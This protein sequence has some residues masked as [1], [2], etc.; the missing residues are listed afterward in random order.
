MIILLSLVY[1]TRDRFPQPVRGRVQAPLQ[2]SKTPGHFFKNSIQ[3]VVAL[4]HS[5]QIRMDNKYQQSGKHRR[6]VSEHGGPRP[7][8]NSFAPRLPNTH[9]W[10]A[11]PVYG[12]WDSLVNTV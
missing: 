12:Y 11:I 2:P 9:T 6:T 10:G 3:S 4:P 5:P 7:A 8:I 1:A